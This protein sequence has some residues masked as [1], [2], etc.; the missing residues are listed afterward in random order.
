MRSNLLHYIFDVIYQE[1]TRSVCVCVCVIYGTAVKFWNMA[2][3]SVPQRAMSTAGESLYKVLGLEKGASP[4]EIKKAYRWGGEVCLEEQSFSVSFI[5]SYFN[6]SFMG[7]YF[8]DQMLYIIFILHCV[9]CFTE[10]MQ[11]LMHVEHSE[12]Q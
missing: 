11:Q 5:S 1:V 7:S 10:I 6:F 2:D 3:S 12:E 4:V 8:N 9:V